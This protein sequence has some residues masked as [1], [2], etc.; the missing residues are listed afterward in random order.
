M[1]SD[2]E[3]DASAS[4]GV[5]YDRSSDVCAR[6]SESVGDDD[7]SSSYGPPEGQSEPG[8]SEAVPT[9]STSS[10]E[11][12]DNSGMDPPVDDEDK[13][14]ADEEGPRGIAEYDSRV[15]TRVY[16]ALLARGGQR[17]I[18]PREECPET[19][20]ASKSNAPCFLSRG[21]GSSGGASSS[22]GG[23]TG[24]NR[25]APR[26]KS[27]GKRPVKAGGGSNSRKLPV[28]KRHRSSVKG[29]DLFD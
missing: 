17:H 27:K 6:A 26:L 18:A 28:D 15:A 4:E 14:P 25:D 13:D 23:S 1:A 29:V 12:G 16:H 9:S 24:N 8:S 3:D 2:R 21:R 5:P 20:T 22:N 7:S 10:E 11:D 19:T